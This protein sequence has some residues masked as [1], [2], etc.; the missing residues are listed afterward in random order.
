MTLTKFDKDSWISSKV[1]CNCLNNL[2]IK[3]IFSKNIL[4]KAPSIKRKV[5]PISIKILLQLTLFNKTFSLIKSLLTAIPIHI[6]PPTNTNFKIIMQSLTLKL[7][8]IQQLKDK[9]NSKQWQRTF[10]EWKRI[11][12]HKNRKIKTWFFTCNL[13]LLCTIP[14]WRMFSKEIV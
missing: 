10:T 8:I 13:L 6:F 14:F 2:K 1:K 12:L 7:S 11:I 4:L 9:D 5:T 3:T